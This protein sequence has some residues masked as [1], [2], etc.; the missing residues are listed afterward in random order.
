MFKISHND[1]ALGH[2]AQVVTTSF[3]YICEVDLIYIHEDD[4]CLVY[5]QAY[6]NLLVFVIILVYNVNLVTAHF[7]I[8][9]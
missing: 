6:C 4:K 7:S 5:V 9:L 3:S 1:L 8:S 2:C